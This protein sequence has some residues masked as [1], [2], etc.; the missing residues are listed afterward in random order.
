[1]QGVLLHRDW[2]PIYGL[3]ADQVR[4]DEQHL[5]STTEVFERAFEI[6]ADPLTVAREPV[7]RVVGICRHFAL[8]HTAL[9]RA[10]HVPARVRC[11]FANY[12]DSS[13]WYDH[14]IT[15]RWDGSRWVRDDPQIDE[16]QA[17]IITPD[18]DPYDQPPERF[19][20]AGEAWIAARSGE[21]DAAR[22]GIFDMWGLAFIAGNVLADVACLNKVELLPWDAWGI[23][24]QWGPHDQLS[25]EVVDVIDD[26]AALT[27][28]DDFET[29]RTRYESDDAVRVPAEITTFI[30]GKALPL[31][32]DL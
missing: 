26:L 29:L 32:L 23:G 6:R 4:F 20:A 31:R 13:K 15:E 5:H 9:L 12:F 7:D 19:L 18:F 11:G 30:D 8:L 10:Q 24:L 17:A 28:S 2:Y 22:F 21:I 3:E 25:A 14:W 27:A 1:V 16:L